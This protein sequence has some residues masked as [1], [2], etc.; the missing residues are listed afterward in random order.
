MSVRALWVDP[1]LVALGALAAVVLVVYGLPL[2]GRTTQVGL[3]WVLMALVHLS[4]A[5]TALRVS[6]LPGAAA[7]TRRLWRTCGV[8]G[9]IYLVG[10]LFQLAAVAGDPR[11]PASATGTVAQTMAVASGTVWLLIIMLSSPLGIES[12]PERSRFWL[13]IATVMVAA[14]TFGC[15]AIELPGT[16]QSA[17]WLLDVAVTVLSGP[18]VFLVGVFAV[19]KLILCG[20]PPF[21]RAAGILCGVAA[22]LEGL[23]QASPGWQLNGGLRWILGGN[24]LASALLVAAARV[25]QLQV[26]AVPR[27]VRPRARRPYSV[28]PY[29]AIAATYA[30]LVYVL[31]TR[32]LTGH[33]WA[34]IGGAILSTSLVVGRQLA[35]FGHIAELLTERDV[36]AARLTA[37]AFH[38]GL[39]G[40]ANREHFMRQLTTALDPAAGS[41]AQVAVVVI[42][43]DDFKPVND[44]H[45]HS[46]GDELLRRV[47]GWLTE[48]VRDGDTVARLGGDE[49][50]VLLTG[51]AAGE[52]DVLADRMSAAL[53]RR[54]RIGT[55]DIEARGSVGVAVGTPGFNTCDELLHDAD[56]A[57][58][59][60]KRW[61]KGLVDAR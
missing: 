10:D 13:D 5:A 42:D 61:N 53:H 36:L 19:V 8:V 45:G 9:G 52:Q 54:T 47:G 25:Q 51:V 27:P 43:L 37:I 35:A 60:A 7:A 18:G 15:Y 48:V 32:G 1:V 20:Q 11:S 34:V 30:L 2:G 33:A 28:L 58:Y 59:A 44:L 24:I 55:A 57:M 46:T 21:T 23:L 50:A 26:Q 39:T 49:F 4:F 12:K 40:L 22:G 31:A 16:A 29:A 56:L 14:A 17:H 3:C 38:D 41:T 6:R